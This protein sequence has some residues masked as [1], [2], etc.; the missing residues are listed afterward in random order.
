MANNKMTTAFLTDLK[1]V[2]NKHNIHIL[3]EDVYDDG[4]I[5][6]GETTEISNEAYLSA[7]E[8]GIAIP[9]EERKKHIFIDE[10]EHIANFINNNNQK[11]KEINYE[12]NV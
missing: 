8:T 10:M 4:G 12:N 11:W 5:L 7:I 1:E 9:T 3:V 2:F 6:H